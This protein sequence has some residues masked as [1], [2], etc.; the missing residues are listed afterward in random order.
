MRTKERAQCMW[1]HA[2]RKLTRNNETHERAPFGWTAV[3]NMSFLP[4]WQEMH[5]K[6]NR[7]PNAF[8]TLVLRAFWEA[9]LAKVRMPLRE[10]VFE[11]GRSQ[12]SSY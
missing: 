6:G 1:F 4:Q 2:P 12:A 9:E 3:H 10:R 8:A 5:E 7:L 11:A